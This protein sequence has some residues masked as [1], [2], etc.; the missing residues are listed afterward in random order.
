MI[1]YRG[2]DLIVPLLCS[3]LNNSMDSNA[4]TNTSLLK[5]EQNIIYFPSR[6]RGT[7]W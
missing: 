7:D 2:M 3:G 1:F 5:G 4:D 6:W